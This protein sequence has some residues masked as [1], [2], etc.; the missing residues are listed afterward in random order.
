[1]LKPSR[2]KSLSIWRA[3]YEHTTLSIL[4]LLPLVVSSM[5]LFVAPF[6]VFSAHLLSV[7]YVICIRNRPIA[8]Y[9]IARSNAF[10]RRRECKRESPS[11]GSGSSW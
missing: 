4:L 11:F 1:M 7:V 9:I 3:S 8:N 5:R 6:P 2:A 10:S